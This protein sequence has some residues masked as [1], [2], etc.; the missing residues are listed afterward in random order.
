V[1]EIVDIVVRFERVDRP[2]SRIIHDGKI[3]V[4]WDAPSS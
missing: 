2:K 3:H 1:E 4:R